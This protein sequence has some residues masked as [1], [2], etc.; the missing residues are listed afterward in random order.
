MAVREIAHAEFYTR[1][2]PDVVEHCVS[3]LGFARAAESV[4]TDRS[5][6]LLRQ[7]AARLVVTSGRGVWRFLARNGDGVADLAFAC[8]DVDQTKRQALNAGAR[9]L[10]AGGPYPVVSGIGGLAHTLLPAAEI[11]SSPPSDRRWARAETGTTGRGPIRRLEHAA[12]RLGGETVE[13]AAEFYREAFGLCELT[14]ADPDIDQGVRPGADSAAFPA[15]STVLCGPTGRAVLTLLTPDPVEVP[16]SDGAPVVPVARLAFLVDDLA[17]ALEE[18]RALGA[19]FP[20]P[21]E[22][23]PRRRAAARSPYPRGALQFEL[24]EGRG[25]HRAEP[26]PV[27]TDRG[28]LSLL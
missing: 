28:R 12:L 16:A 17:L 1:N 6:V 3:R 14:A 2:T 7:G 11:G 4:R 22:P 9:L 20:D 13:S 23:G 18:Y 21:H 10:E 15:E 24:V 25:A 8:E 27:S 19:G 26:E 5:S